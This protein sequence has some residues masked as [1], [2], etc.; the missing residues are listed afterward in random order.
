MSN[1]SRYVLGV[2]VD[3][4][5]DEKVF[6]IVVEI[7]ERAG[8]IERSLDRFNAALESRSWRRLAYVGPGLPGSG[9]S[10]ENVRCPPSAGTPTGPRG[11]VT[12]EGN[13]CRRRIFRLATA[14]PG[15]TQKDASRVLSEAL[16]ATGVVGHAVETVTVAATQAAGKIKAGV[17]K[18][19]EVASDLRCKAIKAAT[20]LPCGVV[21]A[22]AAVVALGLLAVV[23]YPYAAPLLLARPR[24]ALGE[25]PE[26][27][28]KKPKR[29]HDSAGETSTTARDPRQAQRIAEGRDPLPD[30]YVRAKQKR[31]GDQRSLIGDAGRACAGTGPIGGARRSECLRRYIREHS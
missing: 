20:G 15:A 18:G 26:R 14:Q 4:L 22:G 23:L 30:R 19:L 11:D 12:K 5:P 31:A 3:P 9:L 16:F 7:V 29:V 24:R 6:D 2:P 13:L 1:S 27:R 21:Y 17:E 25:A 10:T 28:R 8:T